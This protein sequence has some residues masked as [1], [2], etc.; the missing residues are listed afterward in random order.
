M[1]PGSREPSELSASLVDEDSIIDIDNGDMPV[2]ET[3]QAYEQTLSMTEYSPTGTATE[4]E[5]GGS[6][7][8]GLFKKRKGDPLEEDNTAPLS[9]RR[10]RGLFWGILCLLLAATIFSVLIG[11]RAANQLGGG[12]NHNSSSRDVNF[13]GQHQQ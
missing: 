8:F 11:L 1:T 6:P 2:F 10:R 7:S 12:N 9:R 3:L 4:E 5:D 13:L